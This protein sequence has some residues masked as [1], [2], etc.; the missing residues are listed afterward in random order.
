MGLVVDEIIDIVEERLDIEVA[1][2]RPGVLGYAVIKGAT[3][4]IIDVGHFLPLAFE[5]WFR[6]RD[7][8][9]GAA[10]AHRAAGRRFRLLPRPAG[11][12]DQGRRLSGGRGRR[13]RREALA[14][15]KSGARFD[16]VVT[17]IEMPEMDG[18]ELAEAVRAMPAAAAIP[19]I[20][21]AAM[22]SAEAIERGRARRLP[23]FRRQVRPRRPDRGDQG[24]ERRPRSGG[25]TAMN[26]N[27]ELSEYVTVTD[28]RPAVR[29]A[30]RARA[31]RV[32]AGR[33]SRA[34]RSP[35]RRSRA[36]SIC[37]AASSPRST[38]AAGSICGARDAGQ[39]ADGDRHRVA[40]ANPTAFWSMRSARCSSCPTT[41]ASRIR[42]I[43]T[44]S[45]AR[46]VGRR[47]P[48]RWAAAGRSRRRPGARPQRRSGGRVRAMMTTNESGRER[49]RS[50][51]ARE[52]WSEDV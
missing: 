42:S 34:C 45:S 18:F 4:E 35:A 50:G 7:R 33:A 41:S 8:A 11:A 28:G 30:D 31:G 12:A 3:T 20:A 6:R 14:A 27:R 17:D 16:V 25:V 21:L 46:V 51:F 52:A 22:V 44:A 5:D 10:G 38:C 39:R 24:A 2:D 13:R 49:T 1:S 48:A 40:T 47:V 32:H 43:S 26:D 23:R 29:P 9:G 19:I 15:L 37:A 36:C